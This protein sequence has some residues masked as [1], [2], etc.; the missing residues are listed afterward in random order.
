MCRKRLSFDPCCD[1]KCP[2][3][4]FWEGL[5]LKREGVHITERSREIENCCCLLRKPWTAREIGNAWGL[6]IEKIVGY[7]ATAWK[8]IRLGCERARPYRAI[9]SV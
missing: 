9:S 2:H 4:L 1:Y 8:K 5:N 6:P 7:E 3:N